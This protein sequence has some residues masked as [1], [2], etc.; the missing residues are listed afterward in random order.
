M[1]AGFSGWGSHCRT[2]FGS[3]DTCHG[4]LYPNLLASSSFARTSS[5][6]K[7]RAN[8]LLVPSVNLCSTVTAN[9]TMGECSKRMRNGNFMRKTPSHAR[10]HSRGNQRVCAE[11]KG[12]RV[13]SDRRAAHP[14]KPEFSRWSPPPK[15]LSLRSGEVHIWLIR[16]EQPA[17]QER[18]FLDML[19]S[20]ERSRANR[21]HFAKDRRHFVVARGFLRLVVSRYL[22]TTT[23]QLRFCY[24]AYGKPALD[25]EHRSSQLRFNMSHSHGVALYALTYEREIGVDVEH[26]RADFTSEEIARHF[27]SPFEVETLCALPPEERVTAFFRCWTRKEA[28]IKATGR[29]LSQPLDG[30]DVTLAPGEPATLL[31]TD[32]DSQASAPWFLCDL[33]VGNDY[34]AAL[35]VEGPASKIRYWQGLPY[36]N[37]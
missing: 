13:L 28:Y 18:K 8:K 36:G 1:T 11:L 22:E 32:G 26:I 25:G 2:S 24:G 20:D 15:A 31:R 19:E 29:G 16:L 5:W 3:L 23:E 30:F 33:E 37:G 10:D 21:F 9:R 17:D 27:F 14:L 6:S 35:A 4:P 34:A 7:A 12:I